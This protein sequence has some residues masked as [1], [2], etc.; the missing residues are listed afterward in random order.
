MDRRYKISVQRSWDDKKTEVFFENWGATRR[1]LTLVL[2]DLKRKLKEDPLVY[3]VDVEPKA[4]GAWCKVSFFLL[5]KHGA[6]RGNW[7]KVYIN[8]EKLREKTYKTPHS[9]NWDDVTQRDS[10]TDAATG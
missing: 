2:A 10:T 1:S 4:G 6:D 9:V 8:Y 7:R 5:S 3:R